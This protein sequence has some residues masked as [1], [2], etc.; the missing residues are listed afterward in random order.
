MRYSV[1]TQAEVNRGVR[2]VQKITQGVKAKKAMYSLHGGK[3]LSNSEQTETPPPQN[4]S[5]GFVWFQH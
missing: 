5:V 2:L 1:A 4:K 3:G